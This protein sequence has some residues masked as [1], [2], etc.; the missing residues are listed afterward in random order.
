MPLS[1]RHRDQ[2]TAEKPLDGTKN[3]NNPFLLSFINMPW[4]SDW[5]AIKADCKTYWFYV[6]W[7]QIDFQSSWEMN[8]L[9]RWSCAE[10]RILICS[11]LYF[12][13]VLSWHVSLSNAANQQDWSLLCSSLS[14]GLFSLC[15]YWPEC[16]KHLTLKVDRMGFTANSYCAVG[17]IKFLSEY[18]STWKNKSEMNSRILCII[19]K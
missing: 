7:C 13:P 3:A 4:R 11:T 17:V 16:Y 8:D 2:K 18:I 10:R 15:S 12:S 19:H 14:T 5:S 1:G 9:W 6:F